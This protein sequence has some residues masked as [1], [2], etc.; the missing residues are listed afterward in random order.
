RK[1]G[2]SEGEVLQCEPERLGVRELPLEGVEGRLQ[3][4]ELVVVEIESVEEVV[5]GAKRVELLARELVALRLQWNAERRELRTV[6]IKTAGKCLVGHLAVSLDIRLHVPSGQQATLRHE[7]C[8]Q[9]EL[10]DQL[11]RV[12]R[13][14]PPSL[15]CAR[16]QD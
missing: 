14:R 2:S 16:V 12:V 9:R 5:L 7:K 1:A 6:R 8:D 11:V 13:H 4:R 3:R 15:P 10:P